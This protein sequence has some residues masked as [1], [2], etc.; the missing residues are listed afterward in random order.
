[1]HFAKC[2]REDNPAPLLTTL[3]G[4][5]LRIDVSGPGPNGMNYKIPSDNPFVGTGPGVRGEIWA[6]GLRNPW[7]MTFDPPTKQLW[8]VL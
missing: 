2:Y 6:Y 8:H 4:K 7:K 5:V 1:V 3:L